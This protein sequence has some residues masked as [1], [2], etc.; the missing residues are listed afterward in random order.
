VASILPAGSPHSVSISPTAVTVPGRSTRTVR[1]RLSVPVATAGTSAAFADVAGLIQFTPR[2]GKNGGVA[3]RVPYYFVPQ[4][5]SDID[6]RLD[7]GDLVEDGSATATITNRFGAT[8]GVADWYAWGLDD[9]RDSGL[10]STDIAS[11][12]VQTFPA[13][14]LLVFAIAGERRWSTAADKEFDIAVDLDADGVTDFIVFS[15][16]F[17]LLQLGVPNG[18]VVTG[19]FNPRTGAISLAFFAVAPFDSSTILL[20]ALFSQLCA[21]GS[22]CLTAANPR[23]S[24]SAVAFS[25][26]DNSIVDEVD[27]IASFNAFT[28][29]LSTGGFNVVAPGGS[30][31][32]TV[33]F[34]ATEFATT[35]ALGFLIVSSDNRAS[36]EAETIRVRAS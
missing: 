32:E 36:N 3:L 19:V 9:S 2:S 17:G 30:A 20:P 13:D 33:T 6:T 18:Q 12:G 25:I 23:F 16:D 31:T 1:V 5:V 28:P 4:A 14:G 15:L 7:A 22:P 11:V 10:G 35:P 27:G 21:A 8:T 29:S 24:Y 34:D 26:T